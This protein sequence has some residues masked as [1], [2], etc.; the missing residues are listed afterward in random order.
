MRD[1]QELQAGIETC[2]EGRGDDDDDQEP[3]VDKFHHDVLVIH[4]DPV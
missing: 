4:S 3:V 2:L 1:H